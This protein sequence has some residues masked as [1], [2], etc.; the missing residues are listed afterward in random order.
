MRFSI[1]WLLLFMI[2]VVAGI[3]FNMYSR[4]SGDTKQVPIANTNDTWQN[5]SCTYG[6]P[7]GIFELNRQS[8]AAVVG[9]NQNG[10]NVLAIAHY[11]GQLKPAA[12]V[13]NFMAAALLVSSVY[14]VLLATCRVLAK[15][16][17][18]VLP[19]KRGCQTSDSFYAR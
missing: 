2:M 7:L 5:A 19:S 14:V 10:G 13:L 9:K 6:W 17:V 11:T 8:Q 4:V 12:V 1:R 15:R 16:L 3:A 18:R